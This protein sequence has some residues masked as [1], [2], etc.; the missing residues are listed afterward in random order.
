MVITSSYHEVVRLNNSDA[1]AGE[2]VSSPNSLSS[3]VCLIVLANASALFLVGNNSSEERFR[4]IMKSRRSKAKAQCKLYY[5]RSILWMYA[6]SGTAATCVWW[7]INGTHCDRRDVEHRSPTL[8]SNLGT[9]YCA[10]CGNA[11]AIQPSTFKHEVPGPTFRAR[12]ATSR[13]GT[14]E[15]RSSG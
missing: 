8:L 7:T 11:T 2:S 9:V 13:C 5:S 12:A 15:K 14:N 3:S 6:E 4:K 1:L 10:H